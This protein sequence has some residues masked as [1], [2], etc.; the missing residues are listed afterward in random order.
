MQAELETDGLDRVRIL[1]LMHLHNDGPRGRERSSK[2]LSNAINQAWG[3]AI[4]HDCRR[5]EDPKT[6]YR[7]ACDNLWWTLRNMDRLSKLV[8]GVAPFMIDDSDIGIDRVAAQEDDYRSF[9]MVLS[10][11][12]GDLVATATRFYKANLTGPVQDISP[13]P[14]FSDLTA[15][16]T[17]ADFHKSHQEAYL[18]R[19][20]SAEQVITIL[21]DKAYANLPPLPLVPYVLSVATIVVYRSVIDRQRSAQDVLLAMKDCCDALD[22]LSR[23]WT[24]AAGFVK[25]AKWLFK[26]LVLYRPSHDNIQR[27][28]RV[29]APGS[30]PT[31]L[32]DVGTS[33]PLTELE[34]YHGAISPHSQ[35]M[36][37]VS[38]VATEEA[39]L[40]WDLGQGLDNVVF[41]VYDNM[42][43][44]G[45]FDC[46]NG[47][48]DGGQ[49]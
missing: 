13:F 8:M 29:D 27:P 33:L 4:H 7:S 23:L 22:G 39:L 28:A 19:L 16:T 25:I 1:A 26:Q 34:P 38:E 43:N 48:I 20:S 36:W 21:R 47:N 49:I 40:G 24:S 18:R 9:I 10:T 35:G 37:S 14:S 15:T 3:L 44:A 31:P 41:D 45:F 30:H 32:Q 42:E 11:A 46:L 6:S 12:L 17:F 2:Y 5:P